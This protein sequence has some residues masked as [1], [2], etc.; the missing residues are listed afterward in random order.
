MI[1][2]SQTKIALKR[3]FLLK[4]LTIAVHKTLNTKFVRKLFRTRPSLSLAKQL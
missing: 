1:E 4:V 3:D 2:N